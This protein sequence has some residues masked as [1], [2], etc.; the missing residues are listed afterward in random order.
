MKPEVVALVLYL[1][2]TL[3]ISA[4]LWCVL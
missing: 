1:L 4:W 2:I 3:F